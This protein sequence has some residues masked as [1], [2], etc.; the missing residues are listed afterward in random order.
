MAVRHAILRLNE[1]SSFSFSFPVE[2]CSIQTGDQVHHAH[3]EDWLDVCPGFVSF[4]YVTEDNQHIVINLPFAILKSIRICPHSYVVCF[5]LYRSE[6]KCVTFHMT[7][8]NFEYFIDALCEEDPATPTPTKLFSGLSIETEPFVGSNKH[9]LVDEPEDSIH[10]PKRMKFEAMVHDEMKY[11]ERTC[12]SM[13]HKFQE[14]FHTSSLAVQD[15]IQE[16]SARQVSRGNSL[17]QAEYSI[18]MVLEQAS[19]VMDDYGENMHDA[20]KHFVK[21]IAQ[22]QDEYLGMLVQDV[23]LLSQGWWTHLWS[24]LGNLLLTCGAAAMLY[25]WSL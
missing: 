9:T 7:M 11:V 15:A 22:T 13:Y 24:S 1:E 12:E 6:W 8:T 5:V 19:L 18:R 14:E 25:F 10:T 20:N 3:V 21:D 2:S 4:Y 16:I 17:L 23:A